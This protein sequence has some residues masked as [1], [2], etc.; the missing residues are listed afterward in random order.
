MQLLSSN[1]RITLY[2]L[3][4]SLLLSRSLLD[5]FS[6]SA[7]NDGSTFTLFDR[8]RCSCPADLSSV[9]IF[10]PSLIDTNDNQEH[11]TWVAVFRSGNNKP[12]VLIRDEFFDAMRSATGAVN[13]ASIPNHV[14]LETSSFVKTQKPVAVA[15]LRRS[16]DFDEVWVMDCM[17][18]ALKKEDTDTTCDGGSEYLEAISVAIDTLLQHHL[19]TA[20]CFEGAIRTKATIHSGPLLEDRG[21]VPVATLQKD[22]ASHVSSLDACLE[23]YA[24]RSVA[25][26]V[27]KSPG[28]RQR[29]LE[30]VSRLGRLNREQDM[31]QAS[32]RNDRYSNGSQEDENYDPWAG[33]KR[34]I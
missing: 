29:A 27:A 21:F 8:F 17:R 5:A 20:K 30:I 22:M 1:D 25:T 32:D 28:S 13:Q 4:V 3:L 7:G 31:K 11:H 34:F 23:K 15:R 26:D 12:S 9:Q 6:A 16:E 33:M 10:D 18:C 14:S 19:Q 2:S 24:G